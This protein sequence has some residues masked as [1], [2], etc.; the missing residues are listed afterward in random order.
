MT[1]VGGCSGT[2]GVPLRAECEGSPITAPFVF[3]PIGALSVGRS[4]DAQVV[5]T[6]AY[7]PTIDGAYIVTSP[8]NPLR[9]KLRRATHA[10]ICYA[11]AG[12]NALS[13][14]GFPLRLRPGHVA[15]RS[16]VNPANPGSPTVVRPTYN[17]DDE[18]GSCGFGDLASGTYYF[19]WDPCGVPDGEGATSALD[20]QATD[21]DEPGMWW[22]VV[23]FVTN[24]EAEFDVVDRAGVPLEEVSIQDSNDG[25]YLQ[26]QVGST[27]Y[28][29]REVRAAL[30]AD[31][32]TTEDF[33]ER[34]ALDQFG[35][36]MAEE[37]A[38]T[39]G[40]VR[41][42]CTMSHG[43]RPQSAWGS[44]TRAWITANLWRRMYPDTVDSL[45]TPTIGGVSWLDPAHWSRRLDA[46][47][48][49]AKFFRGGS[50]TNDWVR[51]LQEIA[52]R[53]GA[54]SVEP[55]DA[56]FD[57]A[58]LQA[59]VKALLDAIISTFARAAV[60]FHTSTQVD[61]TGVSTFAMFEAACCAGSPNGRA[62]QNDTTPGAEGL[63]GLYVKLSRYA[64]QTGISTL[65]TA[66]L[67][68]TATQHAA[69]KD[70]IKVVVFPWLDAA[71]GVVFVSK[72]TGNDGNAGTYASQK[73]T[74]TAALAVSTW[75]YVSIEADTY[76]EKI[77][78]NK[79]G[80]STLDRVT[81]MARGAVTI[82]GS[83]IRDGIDTS[84]RSHVLVRGIDF[85]NVVNGWTHS[86]GSGIVFHDCE[87]AGA[88]TTG[89]LI[90]GGTVSARR[91]RVSN[92]PAAVGFSFSGT[93]TV[94]T[95][96]CDLSGCAYG[97]KAFGSAVHVDYG[98]VIHD[99]VT[100]EVWSTGSASTT[101]RNGKVAVGTQPVNNLH[102]A[103][104]VD[105][106]GT[107]VVENGLIYNGN[108]DG[109]LVSYAIHADSD[110]ARVAWRNVVFGKADNDLAVKVWVKNAGATG[111]IVE[112]VGS[113][114]H[115]SGQPFQYAV[116]STSAAPQFA[117]PMSFA[118]WQ[119]LQDR[120]LR[121]VDSGSIEHDTRVACEPSD[122]VPDSAPGNGVRN[123]IGANLTSSYSVDYFAR[124]RESTGPWYAGPWA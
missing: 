5:M 25:A 57:G 116:G 4:E 41:S 114:H 53:F 117:T 8:Q 75:K 48:F 22:K 29:L 56:V 108:A 66:P 12:T 33:D 9:I 120:S 50:G 91:V 100:H 24:P 99:N 58:T 73:K 63:R 118:T 124:L 107:A 18:A 42:Q 103:I 28:P 90:T 17:G 121:A 3:T 38:T 1:R 101:L 55:H 43:A 65:F 98:S 97:V 62:F 112:G 51:R 14:D 20:S 95:R 113:E 79:S 87:I 72:S 94:A 16:Y 67:H 85:V 122:D 19:E 32:L 81:L 105:G 106:S 76:F 59:N 96:R 86:S 11:L 77:T 84:T 49:D 64:A 39:R 31:D 46:D 68:Y 37:Y 36:T 88:S 23:G 82:N 92:S 6:V 70:A 13:A 10:M 7:D 71:L 2:V 21:G 44:N 35:H 102:A 60:L 93:A 123:A 115:D 34:G 109:G 45:T 47:P 15:Q 104:Y 40:F 30:V 52:G 61:V 78:I 110:G 111:N 26:P 54:N 27:T 74:I 119:L 80:S 69:I 89:A 83:G